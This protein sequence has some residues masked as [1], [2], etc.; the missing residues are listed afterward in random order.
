V[1]GF[2]YG[3]QIHTEHAVVR[4]A[5]P[6]LYIVP[7]STAHVV[8]ARVSPVH[9]DQVQQ[10]QT[11][12]LHLSA[13]DQRTTPVIPGIVTK[14]SADTFMDDATGARYYRT[15][16]TPD[17]D[18]VLALTNVTLVPGMPVD[19]F[20]RTGP[21]TPLSYVLKPLTDYFNRAFREG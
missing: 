6:V 21:R 13:F 2:V 17:A 10:G 20:L 14:I 8:Q 15:E 5:E 4:A 12:V 9:I 19:A 11:V 3:L 1:S 18:A 16:V 7:D